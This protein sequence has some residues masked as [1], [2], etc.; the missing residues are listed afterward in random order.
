VIT[1][2]LHL[3]SGDTTVYV[4]N[5]HFTS[6][7]GGEKPTEP[8]R[9]AQAA[10]NAT[11]VEQ[12]LAGDPEAYVVVLGDLNSFYDSPPLDLLRDAGLRHIYEFVEPE[13]PYSYIYQ[14]VSETLD[15]ILVT[16]SLYELLTAVE[17][18]HINADYPLPLP[19]DASARRVSDHDPIVAVFAIK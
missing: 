5:N 2:T 8:R 15:H 6:M 18:V 19:D 10:W 13:R 7:S 3:D 9:T 4:L 11:L 1:T 17:A 14:G 12:I 16:P